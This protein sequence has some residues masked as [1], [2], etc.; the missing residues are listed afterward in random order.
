MGNNITELPR[1]CKEA[2]CVGCGLCV[3]ACPGQAVFL[4][5]A[6]FEPGY[7]SVSLP[8]EFLPLPVVGEEGE[9]LDRS[10]KPVCRAKIVGVNTSSAFDKTTVLTMKIPS[11]MA[12]KA[13]FFK[14]DYTEQSPQL[15]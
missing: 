14:S 13:R 2:V 1:V 9:A 4:I 15:A 8:Y 7:S 10:G 3:S 11:D 5:N 12:E 6:N